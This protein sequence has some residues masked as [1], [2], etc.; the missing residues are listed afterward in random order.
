MAITGDSSTAQG[1]GGTTKDTTAV[2]T[3]GQA[4]TLMSLHRDFV[5]SIAFDHYGRRFATCSGDRTVRVW[6]LGD[7]GEWSSAPGSEWQAH[8]G[9]VTE[10]SW[11]HPEFGQLI[12]TGGADFSATVWEERVGGLGL[13]GSQSGDAGGSNS[14]H[15]STPGSSATRWVN[16]A[17]LTDARKAVTCVQFAPRHLGLKLATGSADGIVRIYEA[18]DVM[19]LNHWPMNGSIDAE[20]GGKG[21]E[22]G[23]TS[24]SWC[25]GRFEPPTLVVGGSS[26]AVS[27]YRYSDASR[28]WNLT[29][30]LPKHDRGVL[31]VSWAP[32]VGRSYHLIA[33]CGQDNILRVHRLKRGMTSDG[34]QKTTSSV[35]LESSQVLDTGASEVWRCEWNVTGTVLASSG[36]GGVVQL[37]KQDFRK[38][39]SCVSEVHGDVNGRGA[40]AAV[41]RT[42]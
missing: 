39:W 40:A 28:A 10:V 38:N 7:S 34:Q 8:R 36:D 22:L 27:V 24:L 20:V 15:G 25:G 19:N 29:V 16:K 30:S 41:A 42:S 26:G 35:E 14:A 31:D 12:A 17:Q 23:V 2:A 37:W 11:S 32:N 21:G 5:H 18:I 13:P 4:Q 9:S 1:V 33:S 3:S 6:D